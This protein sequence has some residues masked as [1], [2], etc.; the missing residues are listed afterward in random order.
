MTEVLRALLSQP[1]TLQQVQALARLID[2]GVLSAVAAEERGPAGAAIVA[3]GMQKLLAG[4]SDDDRHA[5]VQLLSACA[6][7][8]V[9]SNDAELLRGVVVA[10]ADVDQQPPWVRETTERLLSRSQATLLRCWPWSRRLLR[11]FVREPNSALRM[12]FA[13]ASDCPQL[14]VPGAF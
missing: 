13:H 1:Q 6:S 10:C 11:M 3:A 12:R 7:W 9:A 5:G 4:P 2:S 8:A 14:S